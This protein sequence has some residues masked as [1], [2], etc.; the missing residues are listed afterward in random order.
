MDAPSVAKAIVSETE[1][2]RRASFV[3]GVFGGVFGVFGEREHAEGRLGAD[4]DEEENERHADGGVERDARDVGDADEEHSFV[5]GRR[6]R[7][8][9][10]RRRR[11]RLRRRLW[12]R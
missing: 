10:W 8:R 9:R 12:R 5:V 6:G 2:A 7:R 3:G 1:A 11:R 4:R